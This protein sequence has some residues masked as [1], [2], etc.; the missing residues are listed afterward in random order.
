M[1]RQLAWL[2]FA[3]AA[4]ALSGCYYDPGYSYVRGSAAGGGAYY[5]SGSTYYA[6]PGYY[7][8]YYPGYYPGY[9]NGYDGCCYAPGVN[10]GIGGG[11]Y[12]GSRYRGYRGYH[13]Y[14]GQGDYRRGNYSGSRGHGQRG[15]YR[16]GRSGASSGHSSYRAGQS[17]GGHH[18]HRH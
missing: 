1:K 3:V 12:G 10:I 15:N 5:G 11:W 8:G 17:S 18:D 2:L 16:N 13:G 4:A 7:D 6:A 14:R 9:Y